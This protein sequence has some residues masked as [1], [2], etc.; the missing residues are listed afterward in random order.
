MRYAA[1]TNAGRVRSLNED[2]YYIP[3]AGKPDALVM[4]ADGM[5]GHQ[6]GEVASALAVKTVV[7]AVLK[8]LP[9]PQENGEQLVRVC[10]EQ[11]NRAIYQ[12]AQ[13]HAQYSG[14]GTTITMALVGKRQLITGHVG[15]SR[16]Y[17]ITAGG[18]EQ[19]TRDHTLVEALFQAG[20]ITRQEADAHPRRHEITRA[21]GTEPSV[22]VDVSVLPW[23][24]GD[25]LLLCSDGL[26]DELTSEE[27]YAAFGP[28]A[29]A[30]DLESRV[31]RLLLQALE[32]GGR[33]NITL[34]A[35]QNDEEV[36]P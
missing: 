35:V 6:A 11:A 5:G 27:I 1:R 8:S 13:E 25:V 30:G 26:S 29:P 9:V 2:A 7:E 22:A 16:G 12:Q 23:Q 14:M 33:D 4:V 31:G 36:A 34:V 28:D 24:M 17:L 19:V 21:L 3:S 32:K 15:D 10:V 20:I 18:I